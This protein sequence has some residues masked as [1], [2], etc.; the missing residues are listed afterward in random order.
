MEKGHT[1][2]REFRL[3]ASLGYF[4][5]RGVDVMAFNDF[6]PAGHQSGVSI[7]MH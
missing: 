2:E 7:I 6:Y 4:R 1:G 5:S 3:D